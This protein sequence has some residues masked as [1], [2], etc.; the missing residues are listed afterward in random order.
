MA[1]LPKLPKSYL[2]AVIVVITFLMFGPMGGEVVVQNPKEVRAVTWN[3]AAIN[4]NPFEYWITGSEQYN[5]LMEGF[6]AVVK[7]PG[8]A[9]DFVVSELFT[10]QMAGEL[11][12]EMDRAGWVR[13]D[14]VRKKWAEEISHKKSISELITDPVVGKK[15]LISMFDRVTNTIHTESNTVY[16]PTAINCYS[17]DLNKVNQWWPDWIDFVFTHKVS[18]KSKKMTGVKQKHVREMLLP[19]TKDKYPVTD[20]EMEMSI[21]LQTLYGAIFDTVIIHTLNTLD[22][23]WGVVRKE[24]C[25]KLNKGKTSRI[26]SILSDTYTDCDVI[27]LQEASNELLRAIKTHVISGNF[28]IAT[29]SDFDPDR[30]QNSIILLKKSHWSPPED[31]TTAVTSRLEKTLAAGDLVAAAS[32]HK[33]SGSRFVLASYHGDTNGLLTTPVVAAL[34][35]FAQQEPKKIL[36]GLDANTHEKGDH[37]HLGVE[38][39]AQFYVSKDLNTCF[40]ENPNPRNYTTFHARTHLQPQT[41]KGVAHADRALKG[42]RSPKDFILFRRADFSIISTTK[43][44]T[45]NKVYLDDTVIPTLKFPSDHGAVS[46]VLNLR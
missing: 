33:A 2:V 37:E 45:G 18:V 31:S 36:F 10:E 24:M 35:G 25:D 43:D 39:F 34:Y 20:D 29:P 44:N 7:E 27:F 30:N 14:T 3:V 9:Y 5:K 4:N 17:G 28:H 23:N 46:T 19:I 15:R 13:V 40:G 22:K 8:E 1:A 38:E 16:R 42:D 11:F 41:N 26:M 6:A 21:P 12:A 32:V